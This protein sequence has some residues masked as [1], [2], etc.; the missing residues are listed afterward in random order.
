MLRQFTIMA[1]AS[2]SVACVEA[3]TPV[4]GPDGMM[5]WYAIDCRVSQSV[6]YQK[7]GN[8]CPGGYTI[9]DTQGHAGQA[10]IVNKYGGFSIPTYRG[11]MLIKCIGPSNYHVPVN[12]FHSPH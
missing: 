3:V 1:F 12:A 5:N 6:C 11:S 7:A 10:S 8:V 2:L 4:S 9:V